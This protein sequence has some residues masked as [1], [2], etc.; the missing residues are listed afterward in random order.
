MTRRPLVVSIFGTRPEAVKMAPIVRAIA[1]DPDLEGRVL[2]TAQHRELLDAVLDHFDIRPD[3]DLNL[4]E[5][6]QSLDRIAARAISG[7]AEVLREW[8]P[9]F[10]LVHGDT[11]TTVAA[12]LAAF[13]ERIPCGHVEAGL[14]SGH[15]WDPFPEEMDR[16]LADAIAEI[17]LAPTPRAREHLRREGVSEDRIYVTGNSAIDAFLYTVERARPPRRPETAAL[18]GGRRVLAVETHRRE[19]WDGAIAEIARAVG[20]VVDAHPDVEVIYS[21]HPNPVVRDAVHGVL[22][23]KPRVHLCEPFTY[24]EWVYVVAHSY[25]V[26]SDS[27]GIQEEAPAIGKPLIVARRT[28]ERP[29]AIEAGTAWLAGTSYDEIRHALETLLTDR[30]RYQRMARARNPFGDGRAAERTVA[31]VKHRLGLGPRPEP[32]EPHAG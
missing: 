13:F 21:V 18:Q 2:V 20:D 27:G 9:D 23:G 16:L 32:F 31:A 3:A 11:V 24:P 12:S 14:R 28:T 6:R 5:S 7:V 10:V 25:F 8:K 26:L 19:N 22:A 29:E 1:A 17:H 30:E 15:R 4:M